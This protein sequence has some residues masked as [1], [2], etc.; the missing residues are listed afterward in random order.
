MYYFLNFYLVNRMSSL[1]FSITFNYSYLFKKKYFS[2][3]LIFFITELLRS[4]K[5]I[6]HFP[7]LLKSIFVYLHNKNMHV[8]ECGEYKG[9]NDIYLICILD[10][11][12]RIFSGVCVLYQHFLVTSLIQV[13]LT[14]W[15]KVDL[16]FFFEMNVYVLLL[17]EMFCICL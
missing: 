1:S 13:L 16:H 3:C 12:L 4:Y 5:W 8:K 10:W 9:I 15:V 7:K 14:T 2:S 6:Y 11:G 17:D